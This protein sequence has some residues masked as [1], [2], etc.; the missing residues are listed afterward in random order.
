MKTL[1]QLSNDKIAI[2]NLWSRSNHP[3][4]DLD[5]YLKLAEKKNKTDD[6]IQKKDELAKVTYPLIGGCSNLKIIDQS[7]I[8]LHAIK[9]NYDLTGSDIIEIN[10]HIKAHSERLATETITMSQIASD[11]YDSQFY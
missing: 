5:D 11:Y 9:S 3:Q 6:E 10:N 7:P 1:I 2:L 8:D 4:K